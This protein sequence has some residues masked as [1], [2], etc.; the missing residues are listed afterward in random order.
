MPYRYK[1]V[2]VANA[3]TSPDCCILDDSSTLTPQTASP[4]L[5]GDVRNAKKVRVALVSASHSAPKKFKLNE[6][7][8]VVRLM[9]GVTTSTEESGTPVRRL[10]PVGP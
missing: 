1:A 4:L 5:S 8:N 9:M 7:S 3:E 10:L 6:I 2:P